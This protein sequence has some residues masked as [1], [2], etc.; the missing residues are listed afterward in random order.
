MDFTLK[1]Y[2]EL[3]TTLQKGG[4]SFQTLMEFLEFP[5]PRVVILRH[6]VDLLPK[7]SLATALVSTNL[8]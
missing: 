2:R 3:L 4:F 5:K 8:E 1:I 6:D 7:Y